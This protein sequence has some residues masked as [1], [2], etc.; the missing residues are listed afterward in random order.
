MWP[1]ALFTQMLWVI[2][3][4]NCILANT[5]KPIILFVLFPIII[6]MHSRLLNAWVCACW[7][8]V[9]SFIYSTETKPLPYIYFK[10]SSTSKKEKENQKIVAE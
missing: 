2:F 3:F 6:R 1:P 4:F 9:L 8:A 7:L 5:H 10:L